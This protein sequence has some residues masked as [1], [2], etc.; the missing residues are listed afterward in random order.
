MR[1]MSS[2]HEVEIKFRITDFEALTASLQSAHFQLLT[3]RTH[4]MNTL[5][6]LPSR[7]LRA[8][9]ALLRLRQYGDKW[10][11]T[12]KDKAA[13]QEK[14]KSRPEIETQVQNGTATDQIL[15]A[16]GFRTV[17]SYEK[18][19]TEWTDHSGHVVL[20][21]T[22]VGN[23]GEIEGSPEWIDRIAAQLGISEDQ[24]IKASYSELFQEWKRANGSS[25][26]D[27]LFAK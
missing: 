26:Q 5:Y 19:R 4:E 22:P 13:T 17:F 14:H 2:N 20:D 27:M 8:R 10:T 6:D 18:F 11:L 7:E 21:E 25:A 24:Y 12:Y 23:F 16:L 1:D 15:H 3:P 9:G